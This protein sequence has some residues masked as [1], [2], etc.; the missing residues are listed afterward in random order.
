MIYTNWDDVPDHLKTKTALAAMGVKPGPDQLPAA[1]IERYYKKR[2]RW[3]TNIYSLYDANVAIPK[4]ECTPAQLA[5]LARG[6]VAAMAARTC[7]GCGHVAQHAGWLHRGL[8]RYCERIED[9]NN[10]LDHARAGAI[11]WAQRHIDGGRFVV[12]DTET[13]DL[14]GEVIEL[15]II[16]AAGRTLINSR[17]RPLDAIS[18]GA[19]TVHGITDDMLRTAPMYPAIHDDIKAT[20]AA[21]SSVIIYNAA[22][23]D[24]CLQYTAM[25]HGL[26][27]LTYQSTCAMEAYTEYIG[28]WSNYHQSFRWQPL[29][30]GD[31][32]ALGDAR[33]T[34]ALV[35]S[36][37]N[38]KE[39]A[40]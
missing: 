7:Q 39:D 3:H 22:F 20:L 35:Q 6:R 24:Q 30:G 25:I 28:Q 27:P 1:Q 40:G 10:F 5:A 29:P 32:S 12:L 19:V 31:H 21:A 33:A 36:M 23:D 16:D 17:L 2:G 38:T 14:P 13:T 18:A 8:C 15:A 4:R 9:E 37:A 26:T 34:L 11:Q